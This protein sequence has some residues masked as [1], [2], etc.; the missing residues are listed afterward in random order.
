MD[1]DLRHRDVAI[2]LVI[3]RNDEPGRVLLAGRGDRIFVILLIF[4][5][6]DALVEVALAD[7][8]VLLLVVAARLQ[9]RGLFLVAYVEKEL[10]DGDAVT[11]QHLFKLIDLAKSPLRHLVADRLMYPRQQH[12]L[13]M[14]AIEDAETAEQGLRGMRAPEIV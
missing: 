12:V 5:P 9:P 6:V 14:R 13:V 2:P 11:V 4:A 3:R 1:D 7:L 10:Q 8:V